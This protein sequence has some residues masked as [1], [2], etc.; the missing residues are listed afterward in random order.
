MY[1]VGSSD[2]HC[3]LVVLAPAF[4]EGNDC[5]REGIQALFLSF[6]AVPGPVPFGRPIGSPS[7]LH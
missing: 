3:G 5:E 1:G 4:R 6:A 2:T 7:G